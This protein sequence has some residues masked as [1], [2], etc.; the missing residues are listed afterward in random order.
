MLEE[1]HEKLQCKKNT[2]TVLVRT[3]CSKKHFFLLLCNTD[4]ALKNTYIKICLDF[5]LCFKNICRK[6]HGQGIEDT[7][8]S[9]HSL[10]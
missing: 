10:L 3:Q 9:S 4:F 1:E 5:C 8:L 7:V 2:D 6:E